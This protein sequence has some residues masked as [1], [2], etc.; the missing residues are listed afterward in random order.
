MRRFSSRPWNIKRRED[1]LPFVTIVVPA[2][3]EEKV[4]RFKLENLMK[5]DYP[6]DRLKIIVVNDGSTDGT[7]QSIFE[8]QKAKK[9]IKIE[10]LDNP[11]RK[12][13]TYG[14]NLALQK[15]EGEVLVVSDADCFWPPDVLCKAIPYLSDP[16]VGAV[17]GFEKLL[18]PVESWVTKT[19]DFYNDMVHTIRLG[20]SKLY[21]TIF[22]QG[23]FGAYK[24]V[25]SDRFDIDADDSGTALS[26]NQKGF[27][28]LLIPE[29]IYYTYFP[30]AWKEKILIKVRRAR[31]LERIHWRCLKLLIKGKLNIP[32]K[33]FFAEAY[34]YLLNPIIFLLLLISSFLVILESPFLVLIL[35]S[36]VIGAAFVKKPR[37][38]LI[39][40]VQDQLILLVA[41]FSLI[42][43]SE[44]SWKIAVSS[45]SCIDRANL[46]NRG[47]V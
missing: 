27:R 22:F 46:E 9:D 40:I 11:V 21:S 38:A 30:K 10:V 5:L 39:E 12:G 43:R 6:K 17:T 13:K 19:E 28:T 34:M 35:T 33:I 7:L 26:V 24:K 2:Y 44:F 32:K 31:Q 47:L 15:A 23:G 1:Y 20:E 18:N 36:L 8:F 16:S 42:L 4:I 25:I 14:L 45:R 37:V 3:N 29:V 41:I